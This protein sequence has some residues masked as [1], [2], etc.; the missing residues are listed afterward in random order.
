MHPTH[1]VTNQPN[2]FNYNLYTSDRA[3]QNSVAVF[4]GQHATNE[5]ERYGDRA[6]HNLMHNAASAV[7]YTHLTLPTTP[8]V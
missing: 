6:M 2:E 8:Y 5:L 3:L 7:S 1:Q 4:G